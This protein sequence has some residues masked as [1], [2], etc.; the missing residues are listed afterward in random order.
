[1][2]YSG[3]AIDKALLT[4]TDDQRKALAVL[5]EAEREHSSRWWTFLHEMRI[6]GELPQWAM[7]QEVGRHSD[8]ERYEADRVA[9]NS[10]LFG[11]KHHIRSKGEP[12][13]VFISLLDDSSNLDLTRA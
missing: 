2:S 1:M 8:Y 11:K 3:I 13:F 6:R 4:L 10:A 7:E 12:E 9:F 5:I